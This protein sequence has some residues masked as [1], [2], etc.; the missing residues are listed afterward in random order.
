LERADREFRKDQR[1]LVR[2]E[3]AHQAELLRRYAPEDEEQTF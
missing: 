3:K 2:E 1:R